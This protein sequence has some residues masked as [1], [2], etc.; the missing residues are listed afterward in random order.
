MPLAVERTDQAYPTTGPPRKPSNTSSS[1]MAK[2]SVFPFARRSRQSRCSSLANCAQSRRFASRR[3]TRRFV[4]SRSKSTAPPVRA[5]RQAQKSCSARAPKVQFCTGR[6]P[7]TR[8]VSP[9]SPSQNPRDFSNMTST[10]NE[11]D[12]RLAVSNLVQ[13]DCRL[14]KITS[15]QIALLRCASSRRRRRRT[16]GH[17]ASRCRVGCHDLR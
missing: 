5:H 3:G 10:E 8:H 12:S 13:N 9:S 1:S 14:A 16:P 6:E 15:W 4:D 7:P 17:D 11:H 2:N